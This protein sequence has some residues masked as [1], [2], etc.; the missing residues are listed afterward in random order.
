[1][2]MPACCSLS[3]SMEVQDREQA[4][5]LGW[6]VKNGR[7][8]QFSDCSAVSALLM[9]CVATCSGLREQD[10]CMSET[11]LLQGLVICQPLLLLERP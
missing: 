8:R 9:L 3:H 2:A 6:Q 4:L 1:M 10:E 7:S 11:D 5:F